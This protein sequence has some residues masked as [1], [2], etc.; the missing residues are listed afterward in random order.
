MIVGIPKETAAGERRVALVP[1]F[2]KKLKGV[3]VLVEKGAGSAAGIGDSAY[4]AAGAAIAADAKALYAQSDVVLKVQPPTPEEAALLKSGAAV[5]SFLIPSVHADALKALSARKA[6]VF[7]MNL[8]PRIS[9]A[10]FMDALSSQA[11]VSG[12]R[13]VVIASEALPKFFPMLITAA[14]TVSPAKVFVIG[15]GVAGLQAIATAHRM[16]ALVEAYDLRP[17]VK[18][19]I[20]SLGA[21]FVVLDL[22]AADSQTKGGYAKAQSEEFYRKQ[23]ELL[24]KAMSGADVVITTAL[25]PGKPAPKLVTADAVR[26]MREGSVIVD[27]AA[28]QGGNCELTEPGKTVVRHGVE[29]HGPLNLPSALPAQ[30]SQLYARNLV[31]FLGLMLKD[32]KLNTGADDELVRGTAVLRAGE[33]PE[34]PAPAVVGG[35]KQ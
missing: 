31:A 27:L 11:T 20:E 16:G 10:Q 13:A 17:A 7:S 9:R 19:Q 5:V 2:V 29:I 34:P 24:G 35:G 14:G 23:R 28:E 25:V 33:A 30:A 21:K 1:E 4:E 26:G 3:S 6:D 8:L 22:D 32:G 12:Y 15:A 18:E